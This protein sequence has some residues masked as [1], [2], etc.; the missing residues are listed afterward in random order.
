LAFEFFIWLIDIKGKEKWF[1]IIA[2]AG[3]STLTC[4]LIPYILLAIFRMTGF[5]YPVFLNEGVGGIIRSFVVSFVVIW[6]VGLMEKRRWRL[7]L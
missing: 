4:Y 5:V 7:K 2:P 3:T 1:S 6:L